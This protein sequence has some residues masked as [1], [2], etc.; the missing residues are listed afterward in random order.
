MLS[1]HASYLLNPLGL[2]LH[3][4]ATRL[5]RRRLGQCAHH[6]KAVVPAAQSPHRWRSH[7]KNL[8]LRRQPGREVLP[9][10]RRAGTP[11][12]R[13]H[14]ELRHQRGDVLR[15]HSLKWT[16]ALQIVASSRSQL[17]P[18]LN[19]DLLAKPNGSML[20]QGEGWRGREATNPPQRPRAIHYPP[21]QG[22]ARRSRSVRGRRVMA[23][24]SRGVRQG[25]LPSRKSGRTLRGRPVVP[26]A[27]TYA[28]QPT[29]YTHVHDSEGSTESGRLPA[30]MQGAP[31]DLQRVDE[32]ARAR[33]LTSAEA[34]LGARA[35]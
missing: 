4:Q 27:V 7:R 28:P 20:H 17:R 23:H 30:H 15:S 35:P 13:V 9:A 33:A 34:P 24:R 18:S 1:H 5:I 12:K 29:P 22:D 2:L 26:I 21:H 11:Q 10:H 19:Y 25:V 16:F 6:V 32:P 8:Q 14:P 3:V 31:R